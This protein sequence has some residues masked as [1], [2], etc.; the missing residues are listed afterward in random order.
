MPTV[1][2]RSKD[3]LLNVL[4]TFLGVGLFLAPWYLRW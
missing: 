3:I 1:E 2:T 4:S